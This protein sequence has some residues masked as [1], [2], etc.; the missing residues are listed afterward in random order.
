MCPNLFISSPDDCS[1]PAIKASVL[2]TKYILVFRSIGCSLLQLNVRANIGVAINRFL[3]DLLI[4]TGRTNC[5]WPATTTTVAALLVPC[6]YYCCCPAALLPFSCY[7]PRP[8]RRSQLLLRC[9][10]KADRWRIDIVPDQTTEE[11]FV[12]DRSCAAARNCRRSDT[13]Y[14]TVEE[15]NPIEPLRGEPFLL[16]VKRKI[17]DFTYVINFLGLTARLRAVPKDLL[18]SAL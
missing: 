13:A 9:T 18:F 1:S 2:S 17:K 4:D 15:S 12:E 7:C 6:Y 16:R 3:P 10:N 8:I 5:C 11:R 14:N